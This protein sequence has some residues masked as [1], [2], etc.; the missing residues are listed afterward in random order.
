MPIKNEIFY[1]AYMHKLANA[2]LDITDDE[3]QLLKSTWPSFDS[4]P[5][6]IKTANFNPPKDHQY[7]IDKDGIKKFALHD[8]GNVYMSLLYFHHNQD[9]LPVDLRKEAAD[10]IAEHITRWKDPIPDT[11]KDM[12]DDLK[13]HKVE[14]VTR[15]R[16][17]EHHDN[18]N[19]VTDATGD[20]DA[21]RTLTGKDQFKPEDTESLFDKAL[22]DKSET[23]KQASAEH[24]IFGTYPIASFEQVKLASEYFKE[25]WREFEP[26]Q[27]HEYAV[28]LASRMQELDLQVPNHLSRYGGEK[29]ASDCELQTLVRKSYVGEENWPILESLVQKIAQVEPET[30][31][32]ALEVFDKEFQLNKHWDA[33]LS[34]PYRA[35]FALEKKAESAWRYNYR[36]VY[37]SEENLNQLTYLDLKVLLGP[38]AAEKFIYKPKAEFEK[39]DNDKKYLV[40]RL[41]MNYQV[42]S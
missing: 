8:Q 41:A 16:N 22:K 37:I 10:Q 36:N 17:W 7:A 28:K 3:G 19:G 32:E 35:T 29:Y 13:R 21:G 11:L 25:N 4:L 42:V 24:L 30:Y 1:S 31:A 15:E 23:V 27:R 39:L 9:N 14:V 33:S 20:C 18:L 26:K 6:A 12:A 2:N 38:T 34:D 40:A 5:A